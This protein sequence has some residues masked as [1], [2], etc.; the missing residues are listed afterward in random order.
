MTSITP[1]SIRCYQ[2]HNPSPR[3]YSQH[4]I[5]VYSCLVRLPIYD[6][7]YH[8]QYAAKQDLVRGGPA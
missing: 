7:E 1:S 6:Y 3:T 8:R 2:K 5:G 4:N